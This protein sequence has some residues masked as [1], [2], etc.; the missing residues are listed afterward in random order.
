MICNTVHDVTSQSD[1]A[2]KVES[3]EPA[4]EK[5]CCLFLRFLRKGAVVRAQESINSSF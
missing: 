3:G 1:R 2:N 5:S 4:R